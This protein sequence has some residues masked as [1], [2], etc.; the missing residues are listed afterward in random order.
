M[1][2]GC[3]R[4]QRLDAL[5]VRKQLRTGFWKDGGSG[6]TI[7]YFLTPDLQFRVPRRVLEGGLF[8]V[9]LCI[10]FVWQFLRLF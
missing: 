4:R 1:G 3:L 2:C 9:M 5:Q 7:L 8:L 6:S 10:N